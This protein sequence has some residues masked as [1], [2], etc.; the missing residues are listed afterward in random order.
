M[1]N[2]LRLRFETRALHQNRVCVSSP[3]LSLE[4]R[5]PLLNFA[6]EL[7]LCPPPPRRD[8]RS[9]PNLVV[10]SSVSGRQHRELARL[11]SR[12]ASRAL[13]VFAFVRLRTHG[14]KGWRLGR[15]PRLEH[16]ESRDPVFINPSTE[17]LFLIFV[18][19]SQLV[20]D[21]SRVFD[22]GPK[23]SILW[24]LLLIFTPKLLFLTPAPVYAICTDANA[25]FRH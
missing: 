24:W 7:E 5:P 20:S 11:G 8:H 16:D 14:S 25:V 13:H 15:V 4:V 23:I 1:R 6:S 17:P 3:Y 18:I 2:V 12:V 22:F 21:H 9:R 10:C 19:F